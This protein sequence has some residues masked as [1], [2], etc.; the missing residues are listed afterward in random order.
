LKHCQCRHQVASRKLPLCIHL[1]IESERIVC[2]EF[3]ALRRQQVRARFVPIYGSTVDGTILHGTGYFP[4]Y[5][6]S[7]IGAGETMEMNSYYDIL[8]FALPLLL[9]SLIVALP[10]DM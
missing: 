7:D 10:P 4:K 1:R 5:T 3:T 9:M 2:H 8:I 6:A